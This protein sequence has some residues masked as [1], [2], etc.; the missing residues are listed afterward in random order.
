MILNGIN[1]F[2]IKIC[3]INMYMYG[4]IKYRNVYILIR[5]MCIKRVFMVFLI[6]KLKVFYVKKCFVNLF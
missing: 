4:I 1:L 5:N 2:L 3:V 6:V